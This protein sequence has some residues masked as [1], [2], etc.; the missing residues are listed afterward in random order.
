MFNV[1]NEDIRMTSLMSFWC[2]L[3]LFL[4]FRLLTLSMCLFIELY[5]KLC[6]IPERN[7]VLISDLNQ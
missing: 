6:V 1:N 3:Y 5:T 2:F 7:G 4:V